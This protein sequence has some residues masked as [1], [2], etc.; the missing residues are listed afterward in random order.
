MARFTSIH[1]LIF[2]EPAAAFTADGDGFAFETDDEPTAVA[3]RSVADQFGIVED[4]GTEPAAPPAPDAPVDEP[5]PAQVESEPVPPVEAD[6][7]D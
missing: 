5:T 7:T 3:L 6:P 2:T 1:P 4:D